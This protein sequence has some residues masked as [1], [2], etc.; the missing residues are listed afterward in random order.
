MLRHDKKARTSL[1]TQID[2]LYVSASS[3]QDV[4][5]IELAALDTAYTIPFLKYGL[6]VH[7]PYM[8]YAHWLL[9]HRILTG[10]GVEQVQAVAR[11][12]C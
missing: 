12:P 8:V 1:L 9:L 4:E 10:A 7:M 6:Q 5:D 11:Q 2:A 3:R